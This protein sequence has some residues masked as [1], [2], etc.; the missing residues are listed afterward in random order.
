MEDQEGLV[1]LLKAGGR[2]GGSRE[3]KEGGTREG[4]EKRDKGRKGEKDTLMHMHTYM[5]MYM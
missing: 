3:R 4:R 1:E 2:E 5:Y